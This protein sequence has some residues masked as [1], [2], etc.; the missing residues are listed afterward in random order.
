M[1]D[2]KES[3]PFNDVQLIKNLRIYRYFEPQIDYLYC[4]IRDEEST[5][6]YM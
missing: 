2:K 4:D 1:F 6:L 3:M 5:K